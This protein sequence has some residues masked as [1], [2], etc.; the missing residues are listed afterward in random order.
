MNFNHWSKLPWDIGWCHLVFSPPFFYESKSWKV[1]RKL[2]V[3]HFPFVKYYTIYC[4]ASK[5]LFE[6]N[7]ITFKCT[8]ENWRCAL[9][10]QTMKLIE[11]NETCIYPPT[12]EKKKLCLTMKKQYLKLEKEPLMANGF[13]IIAMVWHW[14]ITGRRKLNLSNLLRSQ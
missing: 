6:R 11:W 10:H 1:I 12:P 3:I 13:S 7:D 9:I 2:S 8:N 14:N 5:H 4:D